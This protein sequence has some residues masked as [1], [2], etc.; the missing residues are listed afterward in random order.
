MRE[1][2]PSSADLAALAVIAALA[3]VRV[4][5]M[6]A[7]APVFGSMVLPKRIRVAIAVALVLA[8]MP[9]LAGGPEPRA[10]VSWV[11][12][13]AMG[14]G[15]LGLAAGLAAR[16]VFSAVEAGGELIGVSMGLGFSSTVDPMNGL[17][18]GVTSQFLGVIVGLVFLATDG[19]HLLLRMV[20][21]SFE[22]LPPGQ[23]L[24]SAAAGPAL[25]QSA[26]VILQ[27]MVQLAA[28]VVIVL[29]GVMLAMGFLARVAQRVNLFVLS[30]A[31]SIAVGL[32][33]LRAV[34]PDMIV[35]INGM[36]G[37][38]EAIVSSAIA[39]FA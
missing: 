1:L 30:F 7:V 8:L 6:F 35:W 37:R 38:M 22:A 25:A 2:V 31:V 17:S 18:N 5:S 20:A 26:G 3:S 11:V 21:Q 15:A 24:P 33:T 27:G 14:E 36:L 39:A 32:L 10:E 12:V 19:H 4:L 23:V 34:M 28:P 13:A 9:T 29:L 16:I